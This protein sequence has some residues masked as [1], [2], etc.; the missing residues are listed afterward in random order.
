MRRFKK[1]MAAVLSGALILGSVGVM[2]V[3]AETETAEETSVSYVTSNDVIYQYDFNSKINIGTLT[4]QAFQSDYAA[5]TL[6][7]GEG[8][9][10][11]PG[12]KASETSPSVWF[13]FKED[14]HTTGV[15]W[16]TMDVKAL[17]TDATITIRI[18]NEG[19]TA[20][21]DR[22]DIVKNLMLTKDEK[23]TISCKVDLDGKMYYSFLD[24][25]QQNTGAFKGGVF[26]RFRVTLTGNDSYTVGGEA[27][28]IDNVAVYESENQVNVFANP[29][30]LVFGSSSVA[31]PNVN[32]TEQLVVGV[33]AGIVPDSVAWES[34]NT[35]VA[36]VSSSGEVVAK[37]LGESI[38]TASADGVT[39]ATCK[40]VVGVE[41]LLLVQDFDNETS[42]G[43]GGLEFSVGTDVDSKVAA[44][45]TSILKQNDSDGTNKYLY[46]TAGTEQNRVNIHFPNEYEDGVI[47]IEMHV[48]KVGS[49]W[50]INMYANGTSVW[51]AQKSF[52]GVIYGSNIKTEATTTASSYGSLSEE[53]WVKL[54][55]KI[56]LGSVPG[57]C[58]TYVN[59]IYQ[60][61]VDYAAAKANS[62]NPLK[63]C[64]MLSI[65]VEGNSEA[66][67][68][69][70]GI[71]IDDIAVY[72]NSEQVD[73]FAPEIKEMNLSLDG[74]VG[75]N[76]Y[77]DINNRLA[78]SKNAFMKLTLPNND[79]EEKQIYFSGKTKENNGYYKFTSEV[80]AKDMTG[81]IRVDMY[82]G[83]RKLINSKECSVYGYAEKIL[84]NDEYADAAPLVK[85]LLN[86]GAKAQTYFDVRE[87]NLANQLLTEA[88]KSVADVTK[89]V[90]GD[91][92]GKSIPEPVDGVSFYGSSLSLK[93]ETALNYFFE[94][95]GEKDLYEF[96]NGETK[97]DVKPS[98]G[99]YYVKKPNISAANLENMYPVTVMKDGVEVLSVSY[100]ALQ[101]AYDV[102]SATTDLTKQGND[103]MEELRN[104]VRA[105]YLYHKEAKAYV[106]LQNGSN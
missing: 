71:K 52:L 79:S 68:T 20:T 91:Q 58:E 82:E 24:G 38:I 47:W 81:D 37:K 87:D 56:T 100:S 74:N 27:L 29:T 43:E 106:N 4:T 85:A 61:T 97:L 13:N 64:Q 78:E 1:I 66:D 42:L 89:E 48:S 30:K 31:L 21:N 65:V 53:S 49:P 67:P 28:K 51:N 99:L 39:D 19:G 40:V 14:D 83:D 76:L 55:Y 105:L 101:Y 57:T 50:K 22:A 17:E 41:D 26:N 54:S 88:E 102:L 44:D 2:P 10:Y 94:I 69:T 77:A 32:D 45:S 25:I 60:Y 96:W 63:T 35:N 104:V 59:D 33:D 80:S 18:T 98:G 62:T 75:V 95:D 86:Y 46:L 11:L 103:K 73:F 15:L 90:I 8:Y 92:I 36:T 34:S 23:H 72:R 16:M 7:D 12:A 93:S 3:A 5:Q 9:M 84:S 70:T 6:V